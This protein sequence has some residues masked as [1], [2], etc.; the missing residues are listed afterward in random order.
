MSTKTDALNHTTT[1]IYDANGNKVTEKDA[2]NHT[3]TYVYDAAN[4]VTQVN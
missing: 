1:Y 4:R 2:N 3:T